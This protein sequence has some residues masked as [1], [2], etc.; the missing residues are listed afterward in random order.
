MWSALLK[1]DLASV[2]L[3]LFLGFIFVLL[4]EIFRMYSYRAQTPPGPTPL[5]FVGNVP[6][7]LRD[8]MNFLRSLSQYGEM[9]TVYLGRKPAILLNTLQIVKEAFVQNASSFSGRPSLPV[10][11]WVTE[12]LGILLATFNN[13]WRQQRRFALH[14]LR[15]F[16]LGKKSV[17]ER[18]TEESTYLVQ[19]M[20]K[21][22]G[23]PFDPQHAIQNTVSNI[24]CSIV[25]GDRFEYE[26]KRFEH[27]LEILKENITQSS[28]LVG[29]IF[30]LIPIIKHFPGP[31]QKI[32]ENA[33]ELKSFIRESIAEHRQT[34]DPESPRDF[35]D[36]YL[37]EIEKQKFNKD[38][39]FHE[40][41]MVMTVADLFLAG[42]D[43]TSTTI[44]WGLIFLTQNPDV[45]ERCHEEIV[46][47]LGYDRLP[48]VEDRERLPFTYAMVH[49]VQRC[50]N[51]G[52]TG[53]MHETTQNTQLHGYN[54]P[55]GTEIM[56]NM[57]N[58][59]TSKEHWKYPNSFNPEN[60]LDEKGHFFKSEAFLP[61]SI[62]PRVCLGETLA[63]TELF[64]FLTSLLQRVHFSWPPGESSP[65]MD[66][67]V[68]L[69]RSPHPHKDFNM[70]SALLKL[71]L[72]SV[73]LALFLGFIFVLLFE[74]FRMYSYRAQTPPG[75]T[76]LPFV[77]NV[78]EF[79]KN[80]MEFIR[81]ISQYGEIMSLY[82]GRK[83][84]VVLNTLEV[85]KEA[86]VQN[87]SCFSG[88]PSVPVLN[89]VT[90]GYG[91]VM[92][93]FGHSWRQQRR[94]ALHTLRNFGLGKKS[95]EERVTEES[96]YLVQE[97]LKAEGK[98]FNP[99]HAFQNAVSNI[100]CSI[101]FGDRFEYDNKR[102]KRLLEILKENLVL[103]GSLVGQIF[104]LIPVIEHFPGP[105]QK[106]HQN[107]EEMKAFIRES[108]KVHRE[109]LDPESPRD[110]I[111]AYIL[112]IEK[113]KCNE[114]STFH[115]DNMVMT[116]ADLFL[117]GTDS[118]AT[119]IK[120][121]IIHLTQNPEVQERCHEEIV[122][123]L[124]YD[125]LPSAEDRERL[126]YTYATVHEFQ[127]C[128]NIFPFGVMH[129]L[130]E[131]TTLR[132][133]VIPRLDLASVSLALF[134]GF[135]FLLLFEIF[136]INSYRGH[137]P[138][139]PTPLPFVGNVPEF[140]K[141]PM[142]FIRSISQ[143][144]EI[145]SL[146]LGRKP[147]VVL[148]TLEVVK[149]AFVQN[150]SCFSGRPS[151]PVLNWV[152]DGYGIVMST[153]GHSWR[154][155][156]RFALHTLRN[157]GLGKKSV[158]E[159]VTEE[160]TYL[161]QEMLKAEGKPF[162]PQHA[163]QNAVSNIICSIVFGDRFEY[164]NKRFKHLLEILK[165][166]L[167]L[168][169]SL[170]G[171][172]FN[173][174]PVI[175][176]FPGPHQKIHQNAEEMK[177]F[178]RE[179]VKV[180][181]ETLDPESP[182]D[183]ID[184]YILEI[185]KQKCNEDSTFHED[186]MVMTV[187][188]LFLAGTDSTATTIKWGI[189][190][191]TQNPEVQERCHEEIVRVLGYDRLPSAEDRERL[192][193]TYA[194][195]HEFQR[196]G[197]IVPFGVMHQLTETTTL[198]GFVIPR[199]D[200]ASVSLALFLGF[201]FL[202]LFEIFRINSYRGHIPPGPT[203]LPFVGNVL[204]FMRNPMELIKSAS[205]YGEMTTVYLGRKPAILLNTLQ[206]MKEALVHNASC[207]SGRPSIPVLTWVTDDYGIVM[208]AFGA[209]WRQQRRFALHTL[210]N[211]GLGKKSVEERVTEE[212][213]YL[214]Q[215]MLKAEGKPFDP[216]HVLQNAVSNII[217]SVVFGD[218]FE[219]DN[220]RFKHLLEIL[221]ENITQAGSIVGQVFNLIPIIKH[222][223]GPHQKIYQ[224]AVEL[225][226]FVRESVEAHRETLDPESPRDFI[227]AYLLEM[228][229]T[230]EDST[231]H[232]DNMIMTVSDLFL[233]GTDTT[234]TTI[235]W[236]LIYLTQNLDVQ[237][238]CHEEIVQVL[239][240]D[241]LP[242][243]ED[244]ER[245]PYTYATVHEIL[246]CANI[247]PFGG[248]HQ[249]T[250]TTQ[251]R[252]YTIPK[253]MNILTNL[254]E[255]FTNK[256]HWKHPEAF[257]PENFL[258][259]NQH[260]FKPEAFVPF[261]M[262]PRVCLGETLAKTELF[263]F[264]AS[265][266]QRI[267]FSWPPDLGS[268]SLTLFLGFLFLL[269]FEI[270][271][272][273]SH[274]AQ[275]PPG[276][277]PLPF[278]GIVPYFL[279]NPMGFLRSLSQYGE[280]TTVYLGRKPT[281]LLNTLQIVKEALVQNASC[282][283]GRPM[284]PVLEWFTGG[285]GIVLV[286]FGHS[287]RQQRRFALHTLRNFGLGK[288]SVEERV[289][290][291]STYLNAVSNIICSIVFGDR[292]DYDDERFAY[293][294]EIVRENVT[295]AGSLV[296]QV[297]NLIPIIKHFPGP[298]QKLYQNAEELKAFIRESVKEHRETLD[299]ESLRD[300]IDAYIMEIEKQKSDEDSTFHE[301]NMVMSVADLF[302]AGSDT[303]ATTIRWGLIYL[304]QNPDV[305]ERCH[306]EIVR[307]LGYDRL[308]S[309]D[310]RDQLPYTY[311]T[312]HE[313][314]RCGNIVPCGVPHQTTETAKLHGYDIPKGTEVLINLTD[315]FTNE[316]HWKYPKTFNPENFLDENGH[317]FKPEAFL[318]FSL[319]K[320]RPRVCIGESLAKTELFI[321]MV[322]LLQR[323]SFSWPPGE[324]WPNMDGIVNLGSVSLTLFLGFL[325]LL[326]FEILRIRSHRAQ[327]PPGPAPLP[328]VGTVPYFLMNP[329]GFLRS[330]SQYGE[331]TTVYLGRKPTI[332]L[333]TLQIVKEA[334]VQNA[335]CF[336]G[337]PMIPVLEWVTDGYGIVLA[338]FGHSWRQQRRFALHTLRNFGLGK[339]SVEERVSEESTYLVPEML[340]S[341]GKPF[342]PQHAVQNAVSNIICSI[343][344]GDRFD[345]DDERFAYL[346]EIV[347]E[348]MTQAGSLVGQ[349]FNL[350][351]I[352]KHFPGPHQKL[353][354]NAEEFK[355]F[356]RESVKEHRE[357]LDPESLRDYIDAY[358]ME[359]EKQKSDEDSTFHEQNMVMSVADLFLAGSDTTA[360]TIR[361]GLIYLTQN[362]DVQERCHE[363]IVRV[364]GY[365]RLPS[366][367]DRDQLP[368]TYATVHEIQ[369]CGNIVPCGVPHQTTE[370]AKLHGYDIPK[371]TEVLINLTDIFTNE[372]HWKYP[373]TFNPENFL[374][375][376][377]HFFKPEAFLPFSLGKLRANT[378]S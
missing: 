83:P 363:E 54:I 361:W 377:G 311:A 85:V 48:S 349:V 271:R 118:T 230:T 370:T 328:F 204:E 364:L 171:Q 166:N 222:F 82:L 131:T 30:N 313:I 306:E 151:V 61:F 90:D 355:A 73:S 324:K 285:Y 37:L 298:H 281:I 36:S 189:I 251:L 254:T 235:R 226:G 339:K 87:A 126:P 367:D 71:D 156:R 221:K 69:V 282:F 79:M 110:Y 96:T 115:E 341:E 109:T 378:S 12:G 22:E 144:G 181:R 64:L 100:I 65:N 29:K 134:L 101:V 57:T 358:I 6:H 53:L 164:D 32:Y 46:Q 259:E 258:D 167:V 270:L 277:A 319:G 149:E 152:T 197:N 203:P 359:I 153:F 155:Q 329:M 321:F 275:T 42:T 147:T 290:E 288:K 74:I 129:Q 10:L 35:I 140:M 105:H 117:A 163:F 315:I 249:T 283:S 266:L 212:S 124:G 44:R 56:I 14:T 344:F 3:A 190:H 323:I 342:D 186:N 52:P 1:L 365:D 141:N 296:G 38:S 252:G 246:R 170:V 232:E 178:I 234:A 326:L 123:V 94:F 304:T 201:L 2:S 371:G 331:M 136:R 23:K 59:L 142:E 308:P 219:Y 260:F 180:H 192:P 92:S 76:P 279:M 11:T 236:G 220:K 121:G 238:R 194:T 198:R 240:Y 227:D 351:P 114:D 294:L 237:E 215:E 211:F 267:R 93:T 40:K 162:N 205:Q 356:I 72:A 243:M 218:R 224:N 253:G 77:G 337:R 67:I 207:F 312:V 120:W 150:A 297:F 13:S 225:K 208:A 214:V 272:I 217:C 256:E 68:G 286:T 247:S 27:L 333:N 202:L 357:T 47:V 320:L 51:I 263:L 183:Y 336:S 216:Q 66:G 255:I 132:G 81:S 7:L 376:N 352:I 325:F 330:L 62:G 210:R 348:N 274:R 350:I 242:S 340:K 264:V 307:V 268:V 185:E 375:E 191:L 39:T 223:P 25:F 269:L 346:L 184:A 21:A 5:P 125:R 206:V 17:E 332:L 161:V 80:P 193:Y 75:P 309:M 127:R 19:E 257:N 28:S 314:Q 299:P 248:M 24:I 91:I 148:N 244:R 4:F 165:E 112:E 187:A 250:E 302:L 58:I 43:T 209:S 188:D 280:M 84:T 135:L 241:R 26:N 317:F 239:G 146:Y 369:R 347:K 168:A 169:G 353:Y 31:H 278:V 15:N 34:L 303:T 49:E 145:M 343:V 102:F 199:L 177:A 228:Q 276:P 113:Q 111:D 41:N 172:I 284:I 301:Q 128:G 233:A 292:F 159:R 60:F 18:V 322:S 295:Q 310:D 196:C 368:Y 229:K 175:E 173:L 63:K 334:L 335:S 265:L 174:I 139:G 293:L 372:K 289:T 261:S 362:P 50:G 316:K 119:T 70:W 103:A 16:G 245:L 33:E 95:V 104:N 327:T 318:P 360:T 179:S 116:V 137:F 122:R 99:Q 176:H 338:T 300:Y 138:P 366:M 154:Q 200:L 287:W 106:I 8:P 157:F 97:M 9:T 305:Q 89:W 373:K 195:V 130:T 45:Q 20:L 345:Y 182:R 55:K 273:R 262:G 374:D 213:T 107:A 231:F 86:F 88:R 143:Y 158:E 133:F 78:P 98:P 291:E 108:V 160:S 354:Q